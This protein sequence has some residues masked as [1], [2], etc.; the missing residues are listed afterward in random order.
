MVITD[1]Q[2]KI[3]VFEKI[4]RSNPNVFIFS[5]VKSLNKDDP[6]HQDNIRLG[7]LAELFEYFIASGE[8]GNIMS[9]GEESLGGPI[10]TDRIGYFRYVQIEGAQVYAYKP[11]RT[12]ESALQRKIATDFHLHLREENLEKSDLSDEVG[13]LWDK[14]ML[15][16]VPIRGVLPVN[17]SGKVEEH[18]AFIT[19]FLGHALGQEMLPQL[20]TLIDSGDPL[21]AELRKKTLE[22]MMER[23]GFFRATPFTDALEVP[24]MTVYYT[25]KEMEFFKIVNNVFDLGLTEREFSTIERYLTSVNS[26]LV[27][28]PADLGPRMDMKWDNVGYNVRRIA[29]PT[30]EDILA[31]VSREDLII[32]NR[33]ANALINY[34]IDGTPV[35]VPR[36]HDYSHIET[37]PLTRFTP[38]EAKRYIAASIIY[39][40]MFKLLAEGEYKAAYSLSHMIPVLESGVLEPSKVPELREYEENVLTLNRPITNFY[41]CIEEAEQ[42][43]SHRMP[44][45][46]SRQMLG[47]DGSTDQEHKDK[48]IAYTKQARE[49]LVDIG[50]AIRGNSRTVGYSTVSATLDTLMLRLDS[51]NPYQ[52]LTPLWDGL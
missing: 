12:F 35:L 44:R 23:F 4:A 20:N 9:L 48:L 37:D 46:Y 8:L 49:W 14:A 50:K 11:V 39:Q 29:Q 52:K 7:E 19:Y 3:R 5:I 22:V 24:D 34:D 36:Q 38:E 21:A 16:P 28:N 17:A 51:P 45:F 43:L 30:I 40:R 10:I 18:G 6:E 25:T 15:N 47:N 1:D 31:E 27:I 33:V 13:R 26:K 42:M 2:E 32:K 41:R